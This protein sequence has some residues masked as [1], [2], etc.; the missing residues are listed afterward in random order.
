[1]RHCARR[2]RWTER[3]GGGLVE[4]NL[5]AAYFAKPASSAQATDDTGGHRET[6]T[7]YELLP[8]LSI[9]RHQLRDVDDANFSTDGGGGGHA[10]HKKQIRTQVSRRD[11]NI[12][13]IVLQTL[14][15]VRN[16]GRFSA[17]SAGFQPD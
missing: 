4:A 3:E 1:M 17:S 10:L 5:H 12:T 15:S 16:P 8:L 13:D 14:K 7:N 9:S 6:E 11:E 2:V